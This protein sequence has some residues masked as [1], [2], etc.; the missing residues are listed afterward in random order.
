MTRQVDTVRF[1]TFW[2][3]PTDA[4]LSCGD[5]LLLTVF[6]KAKA[7]SELQARTTKVCSLHLAGPY[8]LSIVNLPVR[9]SYW[10]TDE[11]EYNLSGCWNVRVLGTIMF[12]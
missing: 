4:L 9:Y 12:L 5:V 3:E 10:G 6:F 11:Q 8:N 2:G 1:R 7:K